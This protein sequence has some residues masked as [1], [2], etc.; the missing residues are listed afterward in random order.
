M[1]QRDDL[2]HMARALELARRGLYTTHPNPRVGCVIVR[3]GAIV[4]EGC[5]Q[6]A[7]EPHA[8]VLALRAAGDRARGATVYVTLEPCSHFGRTPPCADALVDAGVARLVAAMTDPNPRVAGRGLARLQAAG[9]ETTAGVLEAEAV[10]LNRGFV[11]RMTR[12]RPWVRVKLA[13]SLDGRTAMASGESQW[14]TGEAA[15]ADVQR[16]RAASSAILTG[17][18]T[19]LKDRPSLNVRLKAPEL[20]V[21]GGVRQPLR[22]ILDPALQTPTD[23]PMLKIE[24][25]TLVLT[26]DA[27]ETRQARLV[28]SGASVATLPGNESR[29][30][31]HAVMAELAAREINEVHVEAGSVL[32]GSLLAEGLVDE[33]VV[34]MAPCLMGS[35]AH[36]LFHL[37]GLETM[38]DRIRLE[39]NDVRAV[40]SDWRI[41]ARPRMTRESES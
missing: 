41:T 1:T 12:G 26:A 31:L 38:A 22:V 16:L 40:G 2:F 6:R 20:G 13:M 33:F 17:I 4:G 39:I 29:L 11:S 15:R 23:L 14:I 10:A 21:E 8:E 35:E 19:V 36:G 37:P 34:Y 32:S 30:D 7:G 24:G 27:D 9:I 3:D 28:E 18:G 5:H 25:E